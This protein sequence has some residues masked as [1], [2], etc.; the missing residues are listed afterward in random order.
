[1]PLLRTNSMDAARTTPMTDPGDHPRGHGMEWASMIGMI[2]R[3]DGV[4]HIT[5]HR[6]GITTNARVTK[7]TIIVKCQVPK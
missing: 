6:T 1:M 5:P 4:G 3:E 2:K 7:I